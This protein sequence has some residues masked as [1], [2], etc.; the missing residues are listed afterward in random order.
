MLDD[1]LDLLICPVC[2]GSF[3]A[4]PDTVRCD[5]GHSFD[6]AKQGYVNL[7]TGSTRPGTADTP[8]M[9]AAR[10]E[11]LTAGHYAPIAARLAQLCADARTIGDAGAGTGYYLAAALPPGGVG[12]AMDVSKPA[13]K[14][15][16]R[17]HPRLG[18]VAADVWRP[19][20]VRDGALDALLN[21]FAPRNPAEFARVLKPEG[22]L[23]V[24]TPGPGHLRP[25]VERLGL[26]RVEEEK[27]AR[28]AATLAEWFVPDVREE[29]AFDLRLGHRAVA[30]AIGMGP[31]A[32]H[33]ITGRVDDLPDPITVQAAVL[34]TTWRP[35]R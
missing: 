21:V 12:L 28:L 35:R 9:V 5:R 34:I 25:L 19:L 14:R 7:L 16:A 29:L 4:L 6:I 8:A 30:A 3:A 15:A 1:V 32:F 24:V 31:S 26:L 11:F 2:R 13:L 27:E 20:P 10:D 33:A 23:L 22:R 17:A 18:A